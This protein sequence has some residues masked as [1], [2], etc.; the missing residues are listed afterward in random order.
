M[1]GFPMRALS[2]FL[3]LAGP[4]FLIVGALH[5]VLGLGADAM[6]GAKV[7]AEAMTDPVLDSQN[8]FYGVAFT[9]YGVLLL[10]SA[11]DLPKYG[12]VLRAVL[13]VFFCAGLARLVSIAFYGL[14]SGPVLL[15]LA[16]ELL[17]PPLIWWW[18]RSAERER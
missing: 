7:P 15:L 3:K 1:N 14:P 11:T 18:L 2:L 17:A 10:L 5:L 4:I 8:R 16:S 12:A 13:A 9:L 6:L